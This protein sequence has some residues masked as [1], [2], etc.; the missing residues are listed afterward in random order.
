MRV[1]RR[2]LA[3]TVFAALLVG[4]WSFAAR[5][6]QPVRVD[7]LF[8]ATGEISLWMALLGAFLLGASLAAGLCLLQL[9]RV[10]LLVRRYR[11]TVRQLER[12][13]H[14]LR[15]LPLAAEGGRL[16]PEPAEA[17]LGPSPPRGG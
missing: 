17:A 9:G 16:P 1:A 13:L 8:G 10:G 14:E 12:E 4:G 7:Y 11:R 5:H 2:V 6:T 15:N 3:G